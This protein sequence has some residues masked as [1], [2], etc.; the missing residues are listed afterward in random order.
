MD[1]VDFLVDFFVT[2]FDIIETVFLWIKD[3]FLH[4]KWVLGGLT[5]VLEVIG[6]WTTWIP[7][8]LMTMI[9]AVLTFAVLYKVLGR[10]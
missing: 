7:P 4:S 3:F 1:I 10:T 2:L 5:Q 6:D 9:T 8:Q